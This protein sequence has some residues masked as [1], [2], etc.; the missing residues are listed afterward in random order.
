MDEQLQQEQ[1]RFVETHKD[2]DTIQR[3]MDGEVIAVSY[4][5]GTPII[6]PFWQACLKLIEDGWLEDEVRRAQKDREN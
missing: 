1:R 5:D 3:N 6:S 4:R 2:A